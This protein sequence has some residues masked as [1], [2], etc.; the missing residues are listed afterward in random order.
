MKAKAGQYWR[1]A[2]PIGAELSEK[3]VHA[4]QQL[5]LFVAS[6][7]KSRVH[8]PAFF[9][10]NRLPLSFYRGGRSGIH[11]ASID[12]WRVDSASNPPY[13]RS[14]GDGQFERI[15]VFD[16]VLLVSAFIML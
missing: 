2:V 15:V 8:R 1:P 12:E 13:L 6:N 3:Q 14:A 10:Q 9:R 5:S 7:K 4:Q 16:A 11:S